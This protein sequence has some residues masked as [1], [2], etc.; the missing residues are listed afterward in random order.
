[1]HPVSKMFPDRSQLTYTIQKPF[2]T[3]KKTYLVL[4]GKKY[5]AIGKGMQHGARIQHVV[6]ERT[7]HAAIHQ[8]EQLAMFSTFQLEGTT[9]DTIH[10]VYQILNE[11]LADVARNFS[12]GALF[13]ENACS[14]V[15]GRL[16]NNNKTPRCQLSDLTYQVVQLSLALFKVTLQ[17]LTSLL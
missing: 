16:G 4:D 7:G 8:R 17:L 15:D 5:F 2:K 11:L 6:F 10:T 1:M 14:P 12:T 9:A 3:F 13:V